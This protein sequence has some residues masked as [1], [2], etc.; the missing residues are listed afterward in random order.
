[1]EKTEFTDLLRKW[2][3]GG[4]VGRRADLREACLHNDLAGGL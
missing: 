2:N 1:M 4:K 3:D